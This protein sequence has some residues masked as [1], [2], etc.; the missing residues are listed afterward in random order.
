MGVTDAANDFR[1]TGAIVRYCKTS[2][3]NVNKK[4]LILERFDVPLSIY[5]NENETIAGCKTNVIYDWEALEFLE[6]P[7]HVNYLDSYA[8]EM[9]TAH[10]NID[11]RG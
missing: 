10:P 9:S 3:L 8:A 2:S 4:Y 7:P 5:N 6:C 11:R 1:G